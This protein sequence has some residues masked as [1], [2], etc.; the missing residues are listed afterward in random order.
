MFGSKDLVGLDIG[1][2][3]IKLVR[4][5]KGKKGFELLNF[6]IMPLPPETIV[7]ETIEKPEVVANAI[8]NLF[9]MEKISTK[10][11][12]TARV[13]GGAED[14]ADLRHRLDR[15]QHIDREGVE[16]EQYLP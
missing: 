11:V 3:S 2:H 14:P 10:E 4:L 13:G 1:T 9:K 5:K 16:A 6:G 7:D 15:V 8:K 12:V